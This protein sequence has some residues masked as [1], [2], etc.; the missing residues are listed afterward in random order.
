MSLE[1]RTLDRIVK[2]FPASQQ[3]SVAELL[4]S[5]AGPEPERMVWD[6]LILSKGSLDNIER[7]LKAARIDY[8]DVL[9]WAE[10]YESD[11]MLRGRDPK[12]IMDEIIAKW[13]DKCR[14][15]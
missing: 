14:G 13:G 1:K 7:Y 5:Y 11:P 8:R 2:E 15:K 3:T 6:I 4:A 9:Y 12:E 10:Y